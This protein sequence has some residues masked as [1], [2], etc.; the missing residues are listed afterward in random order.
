MCIRDRIYIINVL[1]PAVHQKDVKTTVEL[2]FKN[3]RAEYVTDTIILDTF[4]LS[5]KVLGADYSLD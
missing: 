3:G 1:D 4:A 2:T 5:D